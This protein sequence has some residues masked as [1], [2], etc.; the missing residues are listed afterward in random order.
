MYI[1]TTV[2]V[3][4]SGTNS[5]K[6]VQFLS[7]YCG[8]ITVLYYVCFWHVQCSGIIVFV[9]VCVCTRACVYVTYF[10]CNSGDNDTFRLRCTTVKH[11]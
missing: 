10:K 9:C 8:M 2:N 7:W 3:V 1:K 5:Q 4:L 11:S 6:S